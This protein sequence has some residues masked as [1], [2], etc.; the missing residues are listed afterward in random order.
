MDVMTRHYPVVMRLGCGATAIAIPADV[1]WVGWDLVFIERIDAL[2]AYECYLDTYLSE[3]AIPGLL[4]LLEA[5]AAGDGE[6]A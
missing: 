6:V 1:G 3:Q 4:E 5:M 2:P